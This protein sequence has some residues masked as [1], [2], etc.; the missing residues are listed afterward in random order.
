MKKRGLLFVVAL[1]TSIA[2]FGQFE[3]PQLTG[4]GFE[5]IKVKL[6]ADFA[7][8]YQGLNHHAD[9]AVI[10]L[11]K[12]FNLPTANMN[13]EALL[14]PGIRVD[15]TTYLSARHHNEAWVKGGYIL[16][17]KLPFFKSEGINKVMDYLTLKV[18]DMEIN[19]GDAH[20]RRTD[21]G[22]ATTN[23][24]V[25]NYIVDAFTTQIG[26]ELMFRSKGILLMGAVSNGTLKPALSGYRS[27][28]ST[29]IAY[30]TLKELAFYW[31]AGFDKQFNDNLRLRVT[32]SGY[33]QPKQHFGSLYN[34]DRA[35]SRYYLV[36]NPVTYSA[37][38]VD[39]TKNHTSGN[40]SPGLT[41]KD[42]SIM[43]NL[44]TKIH[45]FEFFGTVESFKGTMLSD[46]STDFKQYAAEG[47]YRFGSKEQ[48][49]GGLRYNY[50]KNYLDQSISRLQIAA[51]WYI[52]DPV[53]I[54]LEYVKQTYKEFTTAYGSDA[55]FDGL[56][57][58][59][60]VSF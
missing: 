34:G 44:F 37:N 49:Y 42:N 19:Y 8:Q 25:G 7:L 38:D 22:K 6:G 26:A 50:V 9:S 4:D 27:S 13:I 35:G 57:F 45:G 30:N 51:G 17:D 12:G 10:A 36:M 31:K 11:G 1:L 18:G 24:F 32:L 59:A 21:N 48:I 54:K 28:D 55:G 47:L 58:E 29:Y 60:A 52:V 20:Y 43:F 40:W 46:A 53:L 2:T 56:M 16:I 3:E 39:I 23:L 15:V 33:H 41:N 14:A 5:N